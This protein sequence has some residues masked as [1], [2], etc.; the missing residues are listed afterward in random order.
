M[1][2]R[3]YLMIAFAALVMASCTPKDKAADSNEVA[4]EANEEK[5]D[6]KKDEKDAEFVSE[7]VA[8]NYAEIEL[9][10]LASTRSD[11]AQVKEVAKMLEED[12]NKLLTELQAFAGTKAISVPSEPKDDAKKKIEDLTKEEDIKDFNKEWC[13]E[14][15][16]KHEKTI[17]KFEDR[18]EKTEDADLKIWI[19][20]TLPHLRTHLDKVKACEESLKDSK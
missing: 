15:A 2:L 13:K 9:A 18:A 6:D 20:Q 3:R 16:D 19:T 12:H 1:M 11:N 4:E 5:F 8:S 14:M 10:R 17:E 7:V